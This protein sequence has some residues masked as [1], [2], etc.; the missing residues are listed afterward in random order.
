MSLFNVVNCLRDTYDLIDFF[1]KINKLLPEEGG[2]FF[3]SWNLYPCLKNPPSIVKR[4]FGDINSKN[5]LIRKAIPEFDFIN[6]RLKIN[7]LI[8]GKLEDKEISIKSIHNLKIFSIT[9]IE[10]ALEE[11]KFSKP[12][13]KSSLPNLKKFGN[14]INKMPRMISFFSRKLCN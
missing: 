13:I 9:E 6:Q 2:F 14:D 1:K 10:Y 7:Y 5:Y 12:K 8:N 3:E 4:E 11:S